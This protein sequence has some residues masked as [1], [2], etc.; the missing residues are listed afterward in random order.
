MKVIGEYSFNRGKEVMEQQYPTELAEALRTIELVDAF[1]HKDKVCKEKT[2]EGELLF[3][4]SGL[5][6]AFKKNFLSMGWKPLKVQCTYS[7]QYYVDGYTPPPNVGRAAYREID[8]VKN[9]VGVEVQ[10]GKYAFMVYDVA[11]KMTIFHR[12]GYIQVGIEIVPGKELQKEMS[13][14]VSYFEQFVW[15]LD[16]RGISDI[17]IP[18]LVFGIA[19]DP[20]RGSRAAMPDRS[21][22]QM[23]L[24]TL[25][26]QGDESI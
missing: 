17:D 14:G 16:N 7:T 13:S 10:F 4:P 21:P 22:K 20:D 11:A 8:F 25:E 3:R 1:S 15:D 2:K 26:E 9:Q 19:Q 6:E 12:L 24:F 18:V 23:K 5:N